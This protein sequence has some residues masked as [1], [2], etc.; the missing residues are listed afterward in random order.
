[1]R[2]IKEKNIKTLVKEHNKQITSNC[3]YALDRLVE[4]IVLI[5]INRFNGHHNRLTSDLLPKLK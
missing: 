4:Q 3:L 2:Y 5:T 1:M